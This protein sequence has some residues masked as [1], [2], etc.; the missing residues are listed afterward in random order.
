MTIRL[1]VTV[2]IGFAEKALQTETDVTQ[3]P[4]TAL[5]A[6]TGGQL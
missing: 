5:V 3:F 6:P 2:H 4:C 1:H